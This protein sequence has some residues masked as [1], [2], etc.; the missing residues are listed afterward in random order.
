[1]AASRK[2]I[3]SAAAP[4]DAGVVSVVVQRFN[5]SGIVSS[6]HY[7]TTNGTAV[8]GVNYS[9]TFGT[10][11]FGLGEVFKSISIPLI[12]NT[13]ATGDL[14]FGVNLSSPVNAQLIAPSN[15]V[16]IIQDAEAGGS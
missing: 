12:H 3:D 8:A 10:L 6:V 16:V 5:N 4:E 2:S 15:T 1:M 9:N 14:I 13:N 7:A 11:L